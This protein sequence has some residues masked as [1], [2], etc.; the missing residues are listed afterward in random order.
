MQWMCF[1]RTRVHLLGTKRRSRVIYGV[2]LCCPEQIH[3]G[4]QN[5]KGA[6]VRRNGRFLLSEA[7][8]K[9]CFPGT[10]AVY[11]RRQK[12]NSQG[13]EERDPE[14][15]LEEEHAPAVVLCSV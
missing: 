15:E 5:A 9:R 1:W 6:L 10:R 12:D 11:R 3:S 8:R 7:Q 13:V 14:P 2:K 4:R